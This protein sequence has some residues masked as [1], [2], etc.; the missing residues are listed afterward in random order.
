MKGIFVTFEGSDGS[1]KTS[2]LRAVDK[3]LQDT[4]KTNYI[5]TREPGGS[6]ISEAIRDIILDPKNTEMNPR[7]EALLYA[8]SRSQHVSETIVPALEAGKVVLCDRFVDS[9]LVYQGV[10]RNLGIDPVAMINNFATQGLEPDLTFYF[11]I[12]PEEGIARIQKHRKNQIDRMDV[13]DINFY[14]D[15]ARAYDD[16]ARDNA[17]RYV[18]IDASQPLQK[19][20]ENVMDELRARFVERL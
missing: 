14:H 11:D 13:Q 17:E 7:T 8:A 16:L 4:H 6:K 9:S 10:G 20:I 5:L 18:K 3:Q 1:G 19:V 12:S 15:V 2:V